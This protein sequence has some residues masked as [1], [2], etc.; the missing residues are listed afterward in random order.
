MSR[1]SIEAVPVVNQPRS[2]PAH[3]ISLTPAQ[4][5]PPQSPVTVAIAEL[6]AYSQCNDFTRL[7]LIGGKVLDVKETTHQIDLL[8][9]AAASQ[10]NFLPEEITLSD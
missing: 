1:K 4:T 10:S 2:L 5:A 8:V 6:L 7:N 9:R 3:R